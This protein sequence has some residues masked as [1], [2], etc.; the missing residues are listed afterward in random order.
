MDP[1]GHSLRTLGGGGYPLTIH[2]EGL[3][4]ANWTDSIKAINP[5]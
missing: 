3:I 5:G 2:P 4:E 1:P